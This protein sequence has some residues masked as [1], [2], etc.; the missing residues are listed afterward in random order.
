[1]VSFSGGSGV[2]QA[3][4]T[5]YADSTSALNGSYTDVT[6]IRQFTGLS[7]G[8]YFVALRDKNNTT[9]RTAK[10]FSITPCPTTT[11]TLAPITYTL[12]PTCSGTNQDILINN[13]AGGNG[14]YYMST[15]T[16]GDA[17]SAASG[18]VSLVTGGSRLFTS[19]ASGT[20]YVLITAGNGIMASGGTTCTTTTVAPTTTTTTVAPTTTTTTTASP[21]DTYILTEYECDGAGGCV[22]TGL[23]PYGAFPVGFTKN[24]LR[25]YIPATPTG[26]AYR[27]GSL[28]QSGTPKIIMSTTSYIS[29]PGVLGC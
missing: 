7:V 24:A 22:E 23:Q 10:S 1:M 26:F 20:R 15:T 8:T 13:L 28:F 6:S 17:G 27:V 2:Y 4:S 3:S 21:Y 18:P 25:Y 16:Y 12:T 19:Q 29:C 11:T 9:N 14:T 5:T